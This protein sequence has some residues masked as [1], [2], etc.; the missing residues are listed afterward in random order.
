MN[1]P[2]FHEVQ[3]LTQWWVR[4][5]VLVVA[6][7]GWWAFVVQILLGRPWGDRPAPDWMIWLIFL[8]IGIGLPAL[9]LLAKLVVTVDDTFVRIRWIPF[10]WRT[11]RLADVESANARTYRPIREYGGWG[12][13]W[14]PGRG[15]AWNA[16]GDRGV[17]VDLANGKTLLIGSQR[18]GELEAAI[19]A[20]AK[21]GG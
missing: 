10:A 14:S 21:L 16:S 11:I 4:L 15:M 20:G 5:V 2:A 18:A 17:Q 1:H 3:R 6:A 7:L 12:V 13:R 8:L 9:I 19:R